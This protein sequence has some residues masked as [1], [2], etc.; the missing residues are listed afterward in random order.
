MTQT[1]HLPTGLLSALCYVESTHQAHVVNYADGSDDSLGLCQV[2]LNTAKM[3][4][5]KGSKKELM[6]P[7]INVTYAAKYL[8]KQLARY[9]GDVYK[10]IGAYNSGTYLPSIYGGAVNKQ[11]IQK[12]LLAWS[13][14]R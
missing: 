6:K 1:Y 10:A 5:F 13:E 8:R 3:F 11:Y 14:Q 9:H 2:Q 12:V 4:K 7:K